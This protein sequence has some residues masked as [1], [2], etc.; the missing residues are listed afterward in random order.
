MGAKASENADLVHEMLNREVSMGRLG[1]P[2]EVASQVASP[3]TEL[4]SAPETST[5]WMVAKSNHDRI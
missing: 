1:N 5:Q 2:E 3:P 4:L